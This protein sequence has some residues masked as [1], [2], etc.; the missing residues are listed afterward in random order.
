MQKSS[1]ENKN[2]TDSS[3]SSLISATTSILK[4]KNLDITA[5]E[6]AEIQKKLSHAKA[7]IQNLITEGQRLRLANQKLQEDI[8]LHANRYE[9]CM[10]WEYCINIVLFAII[11]YISQTLHFPFFSKSPSN[12]V[13]ATG[14]GE[15]ETT[16]SKNTLAGGRHSFQSK[17]KIEIIMQSKVA[18]VLV[19][20][21]VMWLG[22]GMGKFIM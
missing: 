11:S 17:S 19:C 4:E 15:K 22:I 18:F 2:E 10:N 14:F 1:I 8:N 9:L 21:L 6:E 20:I 12:G 16:N 3:T 13:T 5:E 7:E